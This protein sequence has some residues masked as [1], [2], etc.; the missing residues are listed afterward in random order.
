MANQHRIAFEHHRGRRHL[1]QLGQAIGFE[2]AQRET[3]IGELLGIGHAPYS[4]DAFHQAILVDHRGTVDRLRRREAVLDDLEHGVEARQ[5]E[6]AHDHPTYAGRHDETV[7]GAGQVIDQ[8]P[9]ELGL[10]V[11]VETDRGVQLGNMLARQDALEEIDELGRHRHIDHEIRACEGENDRHL[12]F[13][14]YQRIGLD[15]VAFAVQQRDHQRPLLVMR[16]Q[17]ADQIGAL[18]AVQHRG[19]Q[20]HR[21]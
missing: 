5:G 20:L 21:Q 7:V 3:K 2:L 8:S 4:V 14:G 15:A 17:P 13:V 18:V 10:A 6:H 1:Q 19:E 9:V 11:L 16:V 12:R